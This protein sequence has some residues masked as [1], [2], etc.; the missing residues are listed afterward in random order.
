MN[1][2]HNFDYV[3]IGSG[4]GGSVSAMRLA[5][6]GYSVA[7][8]EKGK[9]FEPNNF[10]KT[11]WD[12]RRFLWL[13]KLKCFG[14]QAISFFKEVAVLHG[15][16]VGG[17]SLVYAN[18]QLVPPN[19]F[20]ENQ[21]WDNTINWK[22]TL[23]PFY[24]LAQKML[25]TTPIKNLYT[26]DH[27]LKQ[28]AQQMN[29]P[30]TFTPVNV[31]VYFGNTQ[32]A[33]DPYFNGHG[34]KRT[35][36]IECAGCMVGCQHNAKNTLDKNYLYFAEKFGAIIFPQTQ[37]YKI[38]FNPTSQLYTIYAISYFNGQKKHQKIFNTKGL[39]ISAGV[40]G[41]QELLLNQK[42]RYKTLLQLS[43]KLGHHVQTNSESICSITLANQ[44]LNHGVAISSSFKPDEHTQIQVVKYSSGSGIMGKLATLATSNGKPPVRILKLLFNI[45]KQP[46]TFIKILFNKN[47][48][49]VSAAL[50]VMQS[51]DN[52]MTIKWKKTIFGSKI[53]MKNNGNKQVPAYIDIGQKAMY[54]F[55]KNTNG[56]PQNAI[57]EIVFNTAS[58]AHILGGCP[59]GKNNNDSVVNNQF[60]VHEYP[61]MYILDGSIVPC[62]IGVNPSLTITAL[63]EYAMSCIK[64]KENNTQK[65]LNQLLNWQ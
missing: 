1:S 17:G 60:K 21:A 12:I 2:T 50:L 64:E 62:N 13:P 39:V 43:D 34:P 42:Y 54:A 58:T 26:E 55:A 53:T 10:A 25:G 5:E 49:D 28:V 9:R 40:L 38:E 41:T 33:T 52:S 19:S 36:C 20:F 31:G 47:W 46:V 7:V 22:Q 51:I 18:V 16:G 59:M 14:I 45:V 65:P 23:M 3:V 61:N 35:G 44:K 57:A 56:V 32:Q 24:T 37:A 29:V 4:F 27:I 6:K 8:L 48:A 30:H 11:D 63:S 15:V